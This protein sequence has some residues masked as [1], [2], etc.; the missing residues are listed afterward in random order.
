VQISDFRSFY[1][2]IVKNFG[3]IKNALHLTA[4]E[5]RCL[6]ITITGLPQKRFSGTSKTG[7]NTSFNPLH[8]L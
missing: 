3:F 7:T 1:D 4:E 8:P 2:L 5:K 6:T